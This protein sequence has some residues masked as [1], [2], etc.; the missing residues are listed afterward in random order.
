MNF[1]PPISTRPDRA[2]TGLPRPPGQDRT[3]APGPAPGPAPRSFAATGRCSGGLRTASR[4]ERSGESANFRETI[5][6][7]RGNRF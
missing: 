1:D 4:A 6:L 5:T 3:G 7:T 2:T